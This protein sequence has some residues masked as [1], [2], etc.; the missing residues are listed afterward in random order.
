MMKFMFGLFLS[1]MVAEA[2]VASARTVNTV[3]L[4]HGLNLDYYVSAPPGTNEANILIV[5]QGY[6]RDANRTFD[7]AAEAAAKSGRSADTLIVA[8]IFQVPV[9]E[10]GKCHFHGVPPAKTGDALWHCGDWAHGSRAINGPV[11]SF[12]AMDLL[13]ASLLQRDPAAHTVTIAGFSA[14]GQFVQHYIGFANASATAVKFRYV[15]SDPSEFV[16][17][18]PER[19]VPGSAICPKY[20]DWKFGTDHLPAEL[21]RDAAAAR[22]A[23]V[24]ADVNYL[25]GALDT[26]TGRGTAYRLLGKNC[27]AEL[28][29]PYRLQ[30]GE[31]YAVYDR[32][33]LAHGAHS[34]T[35]VPGCAHSVTCVFPSAAARDVLFGHQ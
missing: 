2:G 1:A 24:R 26:G 5:V 8:P 3:P 27:A 17:F 14:G 18:D 31:A 33:A 29:G 4:G 22:A 12:E 10:D 11:T 19:P 23:Y 30:R 16:Y 21:G 32:A 13:V 6:T 28:Q 7:A 9:R 20:N 15:V 35:I 34:L 25:E